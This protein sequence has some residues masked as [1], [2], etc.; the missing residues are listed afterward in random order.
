MKAKQLLFFSLIFT[1]V[2]NGCKKDADSPS[3]TAAPVV[4]AGNDTVVLNTDTLSLQATTNSDSGRWSIISGEGGAL[5]NVKLKNSKFSGNMNSVYLLKWESES[6]CGKSADTLK[7]TFK[8]QVTS[9]TMVNKIHWLGQSDFKIITSQ[10]IMYIDHISTKANDTAGI[11]LITH[12]HDDHFSSAAIAKVCNANT[13]VIGPADCKYKG[14]CKKFITLEP[15]KDTAINEFF[16]IKAVTAYNSYHSKANKWVG[17]VITVDGVT[18]YHAGD[19][20]RIIE[21]K[22]IDCDIAMLPLG[23]TY[24]MATVSDAAESAKDVKAEIAIPMHFG[25]YEGTRA[26]AT[27]F[28]TLLNGLIN[29][30]IKEKE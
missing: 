28:Q 7:V 15:G 8:T 20:Q 18:I 11:I 21:M 6:P 14:I 27:T 12:S 16:N 26:D 19:T 9:E 30:V 24:T 23:Q 13:L 10:T 5:N 29:V 17:Y 1:L 25:M 2:Y 4:S 22:D 3:C